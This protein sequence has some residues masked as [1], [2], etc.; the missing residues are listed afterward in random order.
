MTSRCPLWVIRDRP[1]AARDREMSASP[2][3]AGRGALFQLPSGIGQVRQSSTSPL[4]VTRGLMSSF[5]AQLTRSLR[6]SS[7][8]T[9]RRSAP[10]HGQPARCALLRPSTS[11]IE[12]T[13]AYSRCVCFSIGPT[14]CTPFRQGCLAWLLQIANAR[15]AG[16]LRSAGLGTD[17]GGGGTLNRT[18][19]H[20]AWRVVVK[21]RLHIPAPSSGI[22]RSRWPWET[23]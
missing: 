3:K 22:D 17:V 21:P 13:V 4:P 11:H 5:R 15:R 9:H 18:S 8:G 16:W 10:A 6:T 1:N 20:R 2:P 7:W 12:G 23:F 14:S 19:A